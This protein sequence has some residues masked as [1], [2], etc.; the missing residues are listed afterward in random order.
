MLLNNFYIRRR[1]DMRCKKCGNELQKSDKIMWKCKC[2][3]TYNCTFD[4]LKDIQNKKDS[5]NSEKY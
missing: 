2:G 5:M 4:S 1:V 3:K